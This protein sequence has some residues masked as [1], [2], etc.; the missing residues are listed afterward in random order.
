[1]GRTGCEDKLSND[2]GGLNYKD[3]LSWHDLFANLELAEYFREI[4]LSK[5]VQ[6]N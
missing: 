5:D 6:N 4:M 1:M 3:T 2:K